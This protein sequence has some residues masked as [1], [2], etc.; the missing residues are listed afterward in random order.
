VHSLR[1]FNYRCLRVAGWMGCSATASGS[2]VVYL[3]LIVVSKS[4]HG[5][6]AGCRPTT[7]A[8]PG[9]A[10]RV[11][12]AG[13]SRVW[14]PGHDLRVFP[15]PLFIPA[16]SFIVPLVVRLRVS[17]CEFSQC[18]FSA[19]TVL[20][21]AAAP[22]FS[23]S[24]LACSSGVLLIFPRHG[25]RRG[26]GTEWGMRGRVSVVREERGL[27]GGV[28]WE[29]GWLAG[30]KGTVHRAEEDSRPAKENSF[31]IYRSPGYNDLQCLDPTILRRQPRLTVQ[32]LLKQVQQT[33]NPR[34]AHA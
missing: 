9:P 4:A 8:G 23:T 29:C 30:V 34:N 19:L 24:V 21:A 28:C 5:M 31:V 2:G 17:S 12:W 27:A 13:A 6:P 11:S 32:R 15:F 14:V 1:C 10:H 22:R 20:L 16:L 25:L 26:E 7:T 18:C 3:R 33:I